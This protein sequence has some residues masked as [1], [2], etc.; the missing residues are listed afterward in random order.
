MLTP[1]SPISESLKPY[2]LTGEQAVTFRVECPY[3]KDRQRREWAKQRFDLTENQA[4]RLE[5]RTRKV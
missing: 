4:A 3:K 5:L 1:S 2:F